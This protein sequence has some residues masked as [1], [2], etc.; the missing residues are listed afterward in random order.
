MIVNA[1]RPGEGLYPHVDLHAFADGVVSVSLESSITMDFTAAA[2]MTE[3]AG[4]GAQQGL[5]GPEDAQGGLSH[6]GG[7]DGGD[8]GGT[9]S[10]SV[11][12]ECR[13][14][15]VRLRPGDVMFLSGPARWKWKH[16]R[17]WRINPF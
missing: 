3:C 16:G 10:D 9:E 12:A 13:H 7:G 15:A 17:D 8:G 2:T 11:A 6:K 5:S 1:Y 14:H 4:A